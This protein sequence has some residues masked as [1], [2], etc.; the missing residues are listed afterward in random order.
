MRLFMKKTILLII[1]SLFYVCSGFAQL[2]ISPVPV[3]GEINLNASSATI[4]LSNTTNSSISLSLSLNQVGFSIGIDRCSGK[5]LVKN[6]SCYLVVSVNDSLLPSIQNSADLKNNGLSIVLLKRDKIQ[7]IGS[8]SF[9]QSSIAL[10]D[11]LSKTFFIQ[12]KTSSIKSYNPIISGADSSK[13]EILV[14]RCQNV[15][16]GQTC[17]VSIKLKPQQ[18]GNFSATVS[19]PQVTG[20]ISLSSSISN[21]TIGV[22]LPLVESISISPLSLNFGTLTTFNGSTA[23]NIT[24]SNTGTSVIAPIISVSSKM[25]VV[26][27]RCLSLNPGQSCTV[28]V[29]MKPLLSDVNGSMNESIS[30]QSS[31]TASVNNISAI[32]QLSVPPAYLVGSSQGGTCA[33]GTHFEGAVCVSDIRSCAPSSLTSI[34]LGGNQN[35]TG[36]SWGVCIPQ[37]ASHC[38]NGFVYSSNQCNPATYDVA[39]WNSGTY[40]YDNILSSWETNSFIPF[41]ITSRTQI[42][43]MTF[44]STQYSTTG[45]IGFMIFNNYSPSAGFGSGD[46]LIP[47]LGNTELKPTS[48]FNGNSVTFLFNQSSVVLDPGTYYLG[49]NK[50]FGG[51]ALFIPVFC[52]SPYPFIDTQSGISTTC[53]PHFSIKGTLVP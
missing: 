45:N 9:S 4:Y 12:N 34:I 32:A 30:I 29:A 50:I 42:T 25:S 21:S 24:I 1:I 15:N 33:S 26:F 2:S 3:S 52:G 41:T 8:S 51:G 48:V 40:S 49:F 38:A 28:S 20:S 14:N 46:P 53:T 6:Q 17:S 43:E 39:I 7:Q 37:Q 31:A 16:V 23:Q 36:S 22:I 44:K 19:E 10:D 5:T 47:S 18:A 35:W 11:F 27:N 13:Y